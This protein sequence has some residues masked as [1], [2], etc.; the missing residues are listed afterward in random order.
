MGGTKRNARQAALRGANTSGEQSRCSFVVVEGEV[1]MLLFGIWL[2]SVYEHW[3]VVVFLTT[4][5][6]TDCPFA[7]SLFD[8]YQFCLLDS[9]NPIFEF[10]VIGPNG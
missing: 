4:F 5:G 10:W 6:F 2:C 3:W 7:E 8:T 1:T 9:L